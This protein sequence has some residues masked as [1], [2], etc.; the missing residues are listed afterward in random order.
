M[1]DQLEVKKP[2]SRTSEGRRAYYQKN[3]HQWANYYAKN[4]ASVRLRVKNW[5]AVNREKVSLRQKLERA[6]NPQINRDKCKQWRESN[7]DIWLDGKR[8]WWRKYLKQNKAKKRAY[9]QKNKDRIKAKSSLYAKLHPEV[10]ANIQA[11][12]RALKLGSQVDPKG[13]RAWMKLIRSTPFVNCHWCKDIIPGA[14]V[15]FDHVIALHLGGSHT[16]GNL[17]CSCM[18]C[19]SSKHANVLSDWICQG[20]TF[21]PL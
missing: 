1:P 2:F 10:P 14:D 7:R 8:R 21:L 5:Y 15:H 20:Q 4:T 13:I 11:R 3:K 17:C 9:Y 18:D 16:I 12:R 6:S 19:N